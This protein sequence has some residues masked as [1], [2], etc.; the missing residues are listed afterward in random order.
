MRVT[1]ANIKMILGDLGMI[2]FIILFPH[3]GHFPMLLYPGVVLGLVWGYLKLRHQNFENIGFRFR[4]ISV[5]SLLIGGACGL[6]YAA[7]VYWLLTPFMAHLGFKPANLNDFISLRHH[8]NNY[9]LLLLMACLWVIPYE[10]LVFRG[11]IFSRLRDWFK[12]LSSAYLTSALI[13]SALFALYHYQEGAG[14]VLQIFIFA[15]LQ[16]ALLKQAKGNLWYV[17]FYHILYDCFM[18]TAIYWGYM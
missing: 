10:E 9:L 4:D 3:F 13:T 7:F 12:G 6:A 11:F 8:L 2:A 15:L 18:L 5:K 16:M 17:I 14:A 1:S